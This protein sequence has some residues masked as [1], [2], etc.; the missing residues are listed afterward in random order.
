M[1]YL[2]QF[3]LITFIILFSLAIV[4]AYQLG[5]IILSFIYRKVKPLPETDQRNR[6]AIMISAR[7]E[8]GVIGELLDS[9]RKQNYPKDKYDIYVVA[10]NCT[11]H[12]GDVAEK[13]GAKVYRRF[14]TEQVGKGY[15]LHFLYQEIVSVKG[16]DYYDGYVVFDADNIVDPNFLFEMNKKWATGKYDALTTYRNSKNF[17]TNWLT[18]AYSIWFMHE[19]RHMNYVRDM[20]GAQC[21]I[22]GTG[23]VV[24]KK[25]MQ[26]NN[27]WPFYFLVED[28]QFSVSSTISGYRIGYC[29]SA[30]LYDEQPFTMKQSWN[31]R[32]RWAKGFYQID[33]RY[34]GDLCKGVA[35]EK[36]RRL[37]F[38]DVLMTC[39]PCSLL[40]VGM[41]AMAIW[42]LCT[43]MFMPYYIQLIFRQEM[44]EFIL[45]MLANTCLGTIALAGITVFSEWKRIPA[46]TS[47]KIKYIFT[48]PMYILTYLPITV[49]ALFAK[50]TWKPIKHYSTA[51]LALEENRK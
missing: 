39:L 33:G 25:V 7:N 11:D 20:I 42:I 50:V 14:N 18:A 3:R 2:E 47:D 49:Q 9:L 16:N 21:M 19:A 31:Q 37:A 48:F 38:Y 28:I 35:F 46:K 23:F 17:G 27:G 40:T 30:I 34:I 26:E 4:Y 12:T 6:F 45:F 32:L 24:S 1:A 36:G 10:D 43:S 8:E 13:G 29:D 22:S 41:L 51:E 5:Y 15:A 44:V